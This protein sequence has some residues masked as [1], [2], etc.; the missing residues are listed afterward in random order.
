MEVQM[1][2]KLLTVVQHCVFAK[3]LTEVGS[4]VSVLAVPLFDQPV[5]QLPTFDHKF[6]AFPVLVLDTVE[7]NPDVHD[8]ED[9][10]GN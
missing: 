5:N 1:M 8:V 4:L 2:T 7:R 9:R 6:V 3:G 10:V